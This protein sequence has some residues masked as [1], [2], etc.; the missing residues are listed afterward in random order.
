ME[1]AGAPVGKGDYSWEKVYT[2]FCTPPSEP[3]DDFPVQAEWE[4]W[5]GAGIWADEEGSRGV[6]AHCLCF[7]EGFRWGL[8][9]GRSGRGG[10]AGGR[11]GG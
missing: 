2:D 6:G 8:V 10:R 5:G 1:E 9:E 3:L 11:E 7:V 4:W